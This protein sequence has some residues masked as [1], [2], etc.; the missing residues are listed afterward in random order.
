MTASDH[1]GQ[2][3]TLYHATKASNLGSIR[4]NG[5][6]ASEYSP[7]NPTLTADRSTADRYARSNMINGGEQPGI[8]TVHVPHDRAGEYLHGDAT[9]HDHGDAHGLRKPLPAS[10]V[11]GTEA[12]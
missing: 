2:Q 7:G 4:A 12:L 6:T 1:L 3:F 9:A 10:M 8:V 5:L 11:H